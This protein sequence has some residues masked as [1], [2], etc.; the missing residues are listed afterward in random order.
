MV[1]TVLVI[2]GMGSSWHK[3][4]TWLHAHGQRLLELFRLD[5]IQ[6]WCPEGNSTGRREWVPYAGDGKACQSVDRPERMW[7]EFAWLPSAA[8]KLGDTLVLAFSN[9]CVMAG[10]LQ[11]VYPE[12]ITGVILGSGVPGTYESMK[13]FRQIR[14]VMSIGTEEEFFGGPSGLQAVANAML[15]RTLQFSGRHCFEPEALWSALLSD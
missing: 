11:R 8:D 2:G 5:A 3:D 15:A 4:G 10:E 1:K 9:G 12:K 13:R 7:E 14:V 6:V